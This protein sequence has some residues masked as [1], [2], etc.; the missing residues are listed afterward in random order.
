VLNAAS[1]C[2][3]RVGVKLAL[4]VKLSLPLEAVL[5]ELSIIAAI[6]A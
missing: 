4:P 6:P 2:R 3:Q 1:L 5:G